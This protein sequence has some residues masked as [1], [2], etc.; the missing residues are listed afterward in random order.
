MTESCMSSL[1]MSINCESDTSNVSGNAV[2]GNEG[3]AD[4]AT[5]HKQF[6]NSEMSSACL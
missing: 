2:S 1:S 3:L 4:S 5:T 6:T